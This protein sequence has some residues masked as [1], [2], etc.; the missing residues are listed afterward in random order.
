MS[1]RPESWYLPLR[2]LPCAACG[3]PAEGI[4]VFPSERVI[5]HA[6]DI[7]RPCRLPNLPHW[8]AEDGR[9]TP[10]TQPRRVA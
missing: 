3:K 8:A 9:P 6:E 4:A 1:T 7:W 10:D 5:T 2:G